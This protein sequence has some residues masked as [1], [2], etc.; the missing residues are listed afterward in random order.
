MEKARNKRDSRENALKIPRPLAIG[1][2]VL[3][4]LPDTWWK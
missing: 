1:K 3:P 2:G 4:L